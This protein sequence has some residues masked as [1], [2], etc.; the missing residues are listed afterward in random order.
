MIKKLFIKNFQKHARLEIELDPSVTTIIGRTD[1][2]KSA[3]V[4]ALSMI[5]FNDARGKAFVRHGQSD[6]VVGL[7]F[8]DG[9]RVVR[10]KGKKNEV[11][12]DQA[13]FKAFNNQY[14]PEIVELLNVDEELTIQHQHDPIF[15]LSD[16][17]GNVAK[18]LNRIV[19]LKII[20]ETL[21]SLKRKLREAGTKVK[22]FDEELLKAQ[23][24]ASAFAPL[25]E[26]DEINAFEAAQTLAVELDDLYDCIFLLG[27]IS[28]PELPE[29]PP[30]RN[31]DAVK[32]E[33]KEL[34]KFKAYITSNEKQLKEKF[35]ELEA[36]AK[37]LS[38]YK[39]CGECNQPLRKEES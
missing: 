15:W 24:K 21:A 12:L 1:S 17:S 28:I 31:L 18:K 4:R 32:K 10:T 7:E 33:I 23:A 39:L 22:I 14:P 30:E 16:S 9:T 34:K 19:D 29:P 35:L 3:I 36:T 2:G 6:A 8:E 11:K 38:A 27:R 20:D 25:E 37:S 26:L 5:L 13:V